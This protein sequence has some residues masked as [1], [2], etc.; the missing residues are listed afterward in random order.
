MEDLG[1]QIAA[2]NVNKEKKAPQ[3]DCDGAGMSLLY[4]PVCKPVDEE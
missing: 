4:C 1:E 2:L 3:C